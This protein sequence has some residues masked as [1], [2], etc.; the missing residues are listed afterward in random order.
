MPGSPS[1]A[2]RFDREPRRVPS[3]VKFTLETGV[4]SRTAE[5]RSRLIRLLAAS[6]VSDDPSSVL[7]TDRVR[8]IPR[9]TLLEVITRDEEIARRIRESAQANEYEF[10]QQNSRN[11]TCTIQMH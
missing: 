4:C 5:I 1:E 11:F 10:S 6:Q 9:E 2:S 7:S 3:C 8:L